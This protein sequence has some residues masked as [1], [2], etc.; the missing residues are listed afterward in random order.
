MRSLRPPFW[1]PGGVGGLWGEPRGEPQRDAALGRWGIEGPVASAA[2]HA[3]PAWSGI[4]TSLWWLLVRT[5]L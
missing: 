4:G 3:D 5:P 1:D 2:A